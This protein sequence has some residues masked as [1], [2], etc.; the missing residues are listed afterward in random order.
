[1][2]KRAFES[3]N[4]F[5]RAIGFF[6]DEGFGRWII[7]VALLEIGAFPPIGAGDDIHFAIMIEIAIVGALAPEIRG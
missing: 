6:A 5:I 3:G 7:F 1:L 4:L 2:A